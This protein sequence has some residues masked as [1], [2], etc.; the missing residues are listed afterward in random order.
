MSLDKNQFYDCRLDIS[1]IC[2][3][4]DGKEELL[5]FSAHRQKLCKLAYFDKLFEMST[6]DEILIEKPNF[7][8]VFKICVPFAKPTIDCFLKSIYDS[9]FDHDEDPMDIM[10]VG[11]YFGVK[12]DLISILEKVVT[13]YLPNR[14]D[15]KSKKYQ[16][17]LLKFLLNVYQSAIPANIVNSLLSRFYACLDDPIP[18]LKVIKDIPKKFYNPKL[19]GDHDNILYLPEGCGEVEY[20]DLVFKVSNSYAC[21]DKDDSYGFWVTCKRKNDPLKVEWATE[22]KKLSENG[23]TATVKLILFNCFS[24][25]SEEYLEDDNGKRKE[26]SF[27]TPFE[28]VYRGYKRGRYGTTCENNLFYFTFCFEIHWC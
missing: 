14:T 1:C 13:K 15:P 7:Q 16:N 12:S 6:P 24:G 25:W 22:A 20:D 3:S 21:I 17:N 27:P 26:L 28:Y 11:L 4:L 19:I 8:L 18:L 9:D 2:S 23:K 10:F 5:Q